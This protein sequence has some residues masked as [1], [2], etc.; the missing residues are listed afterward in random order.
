MECARTVENV[1]IGAAACLGFSTSNP[2]VATV[3][4]STAYILKR[5]RRDD[6]VT[7]GG[8][9]ESPMICFEEGLFHW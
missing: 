3:A 8:V 1:E 2:D 9:D 7:C 4:F 6:R 5:D